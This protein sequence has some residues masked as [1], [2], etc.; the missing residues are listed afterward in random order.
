MSDHG[1]PIQKISD[2]V[3]HKNTKIT[4]TV[5]RH[6]LKPEIRDGAEHMNDIFQS[7]NEQS[8]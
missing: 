4:E 6:Q 2:L 5:Y 8:A 1:V 3:G 7:K